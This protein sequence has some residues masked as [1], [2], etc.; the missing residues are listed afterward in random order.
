MDNIDEL[1]ITKEFEFDFN[2]YIF[3]DIDED[4]DEI[5][6]DL[7]NVQETKLPTEEEGVNDDGE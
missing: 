5:M 6:M 3:D 2:D 7:E 4:D 1:E